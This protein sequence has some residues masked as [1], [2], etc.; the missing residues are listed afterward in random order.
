MKVIYINKG[1]GMLNLESMINNR[2]T[3]STLPNFINITKPDII[4][5]YLLPIRHK[6]IQSSRCP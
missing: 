2:Q 5:T 6:N 4:Y 1:V 3:L